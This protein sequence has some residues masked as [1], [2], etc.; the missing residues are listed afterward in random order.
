M[1]VAAVISDLMLYSRIE[2]AA[3]AAS[4]SLV[5]VD[6]PSELH[7]DFDL[8]LVDWSA[9]QSDWD[10]VLRERGDPRVILFGQHTD[11]AAHAEARVAGLG[12][13]WARS[14]LIDKLSTLVAGA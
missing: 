6:T 8:V 12:P 1:R 5:R 11:L 13:M 9:R 4:A 10:G 14:K 2:S 7:G 3:T